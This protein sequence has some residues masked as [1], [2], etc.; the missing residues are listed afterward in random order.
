MLKTA[1]YLITFFVTMYALSGVN[2]KTITRS[3]QESR[4]FLLSIFLG[5]AIAYLVAEFLLG[6]RIL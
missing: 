2:F 5:M 6:L 3:N 4:V 1:I